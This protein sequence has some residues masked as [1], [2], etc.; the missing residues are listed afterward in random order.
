MEELIWKVR[1]ALVLL[2]CETNNNNSLSGSHIHHAVILPPRIDSRSDLIRLTAHHKGLAS[3][4]DIIGP[5][6]LGKIARASENWVYARCNLQSQAER[7]NN[8][9]MLHVVYALLKLVVGFAKDGTHRNTKANP[10]S[11]ARDEHAGTDRAS[12]MART[13]VSHSNLD[14]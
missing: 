14:T 6:T 10:C 3:E 13:A 7:N 12:G 1:R 8:G 4:I 5:P 11:H 2:W 9:S